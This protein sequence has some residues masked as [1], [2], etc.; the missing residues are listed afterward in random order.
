MHRIINHPSSDSKYDP[1]LE[2][3]SGLLSKACL[4]AIHWWV[5]KEHK[6]HKSFSTS[7]DNLEKDFLQFTK[8]YSVF[9]FITSDKRLEVLNKLQSDCF[10]SDVL[11]KGLDANLWEY[12][13]LTE[14][15]YLRKKDGKLIT[16]THL[17]MLSKFATL[18]NP[19]EFTMLDRNAVA[20]ISDVLEAYDYEVTKSLLKSDYDYFKSR[21]DHFKV[22]VMQNDYFKDIETHFNYLQNTFPDHP[23]SR[24]AFINRVLD[25]FLWHLYNMPINA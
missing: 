19:E 6:Y 2:K 10:I 17:S 1:Y 25:K 24:P 9:K 13:P 3:A 18:I 16:S 11:N 8:D 14:T 7:S 22:I 15:S 20:S 21:F 4:D 5:L 23:I 12:L